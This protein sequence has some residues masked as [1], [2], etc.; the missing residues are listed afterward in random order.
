MYF[1]KL[2][3]R[4]DDIDQ[5]IAEVESIELVSNNEINKLALEYLDSSQNLIRTLLLSYKSQFESGLAKDNFE[6]A[7]RELN[8]NKLFF[9]NEYY[10]NA[11]TKAEIEL[12]AVEERHSDSKPRV[13][14]AANRLKIDRVKLTL[15]TSSDNLISEVTLT[16][17][18]GIFLNRCKS[19]S[20]GSVSIDSLKNYYNQEYTMVYFGQLTCSRKGCSR[21]ICQQKLV[22]HT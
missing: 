21:R 10:K 4:I 18:Q 15:H 9:N 16:E 12:K 11:V 7:K 22:I 6:D 14:N 13:V 19:K 5:A 20:M 17:L 8:G 2:E 3:S 1:K